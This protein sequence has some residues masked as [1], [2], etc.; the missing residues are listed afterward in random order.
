MRSGGS[1]PPNNF[2]REGQGFTG[3][4]RGMGARAR[5]AGPNDCRASWGG[6]GS[7]RHRCAQPPPAQL[8]LPPQPLPSFRPNPRLRPS[9][10]CCWLFLQAKGGHEGGKIIGPDLP[11]I[12]VLYNRARAPGPEME[13]ETLRIG[14]VSLFLSDQHRDRETGRETGTTG[15]KN[16]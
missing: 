12:L 8:L 11:L 10:G 13:V 1:R 7:H 2:Q 4:G 3:S 16:K 6:P 9:S 5:Q 15:T 14:T